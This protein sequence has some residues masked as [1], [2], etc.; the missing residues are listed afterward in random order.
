MSIFDV[1]MITN[2]TIPKKNIPQIE[3]PMMRLQRFEAKKITKK[4]DYIYLKSKWFYYS[5][6]SQNYLKIPEIKH[7][8]SIEKGRP[9]STQ[10]LIDI[11]NNGIVPQYIDT[12]YNPSNQDGYYNLFDS[13]RILKASNNPRIH[14]WIELLISTLCHWNKEWIDWLHSA[15]LYKHS[16]LSE[17]RIPCVVFYGIGWSGK[18]TFTQLLS[19]I[20]W[21]ENVKE[22]I[23]KQKLESWFDIVQWNKLIYEFAEITTNNAQID[24]WIFNKLKTIIFAQKIM[25]NEKHRAVREVDNYGWCL[26]NS[27]SNRPILLDNWDTWNRRFTFLK[28]EHKLTENESE[29]IYSV[30]DPW[31]GNYDKNALADYIAWLYQEFP[32]IVTIKSFLCLE[33]S[34]KSLITQNSESEVDELIRYIKENL[35][36][37]RL[38]ISDIDNVIHSFVLMNGECDEYSLKRLFKSQSPFNKSRWI[39][40]WKNVWYYDIK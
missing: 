1:P 22:N 10:E 17:V 26:I 38:P 6:K 4:T 33:N 19:W 31:N 40:E 21:H 29:L 13:D 23:D 8:L 27:N 15:V 24:K 14:P 3:T 35:K 34:D 16:H 18:S 37:I 25:C 28:S 30:I 11:T 32:N 2:N 20:F 12:C 36:W 9:L 7:M 39:V 5:T